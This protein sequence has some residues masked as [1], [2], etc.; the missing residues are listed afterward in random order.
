MDIQTDVQTD[1]GDNYIPFAFLI[2]R[3]G[4]QCHAK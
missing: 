4:K 1:G 3:G 2:N